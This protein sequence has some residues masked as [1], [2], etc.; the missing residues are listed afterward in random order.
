MTRIIVDSNLNRVIAGNTTLVICM[1]AAYMMILPIIILA[2]GTA[3]LLEFEE[4]QPRMS[5]RKLAE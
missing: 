2:K 4:A 3:G 5:T 1:A